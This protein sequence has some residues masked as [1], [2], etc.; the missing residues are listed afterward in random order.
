MYGLRMTPEEEQVH[1][2]SRVDILEPF[3]DEELRELLRRNPDTYLQ[4]RFDS[5]TSCVPF[6]R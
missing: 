2:L 1:V 6:F 5:S 3:S 4:G